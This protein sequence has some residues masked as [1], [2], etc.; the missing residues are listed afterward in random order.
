VSVVPSPPDDR[1]S[2]RRVPQQSRSRSRFERILEVTSELVVAG[3]VESVNTRVIAAAAGI[4]VASL[5]QYFA[6]KEEVLLA[7]VERDIAEIDRQV[8]Q[9]LSLLSVLSV[10]CIVETTLRAFVKVYRRRPAFVVI[11]MR[12]RTNT[13]I[14]DYCRAHNRRVAADL[15]DLACQCGMVQE[16]S[17]RL[18]A[19]LAVEVADRLLQVAFE[20]S[21]EGDTRVID[22]AIAVVTTYLETHATP[23][24]VAGVAYEGLEPE[25]G[26]PRERRGERSAAGP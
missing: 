23:Q 25:P 20:E 22:E 7:L 17:V 12:G 4:P 3:G 1:A 21:L 14:N 15:F 9:D 16:P 26:S 10:R 8:G 11:W 2:R 19:Q 13:A 18:Y 24:G 6:D 5:Y